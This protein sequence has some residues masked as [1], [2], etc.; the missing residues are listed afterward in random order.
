MENHS[1]D[2]AKRILAIY[3]RLRQGKTVYKAAMSEAYGV[4]QRTIQRDITDIQCF[5]QDLCMETGS[6]QEIVFDKHKG[7]YLLQSKQNHY[8]SEKETWSVCRVQ[9]E[10][11][12]CLSEK[13]ILVVCRV[14]LGSEALVKAELFPIVDSLI[15]LCGESKVMDV[16]KLLQDGMGNYAE[17]RHGRRLIEQLWN[18]ENA[19]KGKKYIEILYDDSKK[20]DQVV[21]KLRPIKVIYVESYFYLVAAV[22]DKEYAEVKGK[23]EERDCFK[24]GK[25]HVFYQIDRILEC[26]VEER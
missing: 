9:V 15:A 2:K 10:Q 11:K 7:G 26:T 1:E 16:E 24:R 14:L 25:Q 3:T 5:L 4:S 18:L 12:H 20:G 19:V 22:L 8:L 23:K 21:Q 17:P 13:E 6:I